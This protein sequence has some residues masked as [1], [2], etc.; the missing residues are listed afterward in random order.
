MASSVKRRFEQFERMIKK[1]QPSSNNLPFDDPDDEDIGNVN[2]RPREK[3]IHPRKE[4]DEEDEEKV[5]SILKASPSYLVSK[6][7]KVLT[8]HPPDRPCIQPTYIPK[9][10]ANTLP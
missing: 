8:L 1:N 2:P 3:K 7:S 4:R 6:P 10:T 5:K 9:H